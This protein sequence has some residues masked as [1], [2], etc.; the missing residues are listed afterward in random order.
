[1]GSPPGQYRWGRPEGRAPTTA[2]PDSAKPRLALSVPAATTMIMAAGQRGTKR[3]ASRRAAS[4][5]T[6]NPSESRSCWLSANQ[7]LLSGASPVS[8]RICE[9]RI[10]QAAAC[11]KPE[12][13]G[14]LT[15]FSSQPKR[16]RPSSNCKPPDIRASQ[17]ASATQ[18]SLAGSARPDSDAPI[19]R[20]LSAVGPTPRRVDELQ[21][22][23]TTAGTMEA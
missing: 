10:S 21:S 6:P 1:M 2:P 23:A 22:T 15:R 9:A 18:V 7:S 13:T 14:E 5:P 11:V 4:E 19:S 16:P 8:A 17:T 12:S 20:L 3:L